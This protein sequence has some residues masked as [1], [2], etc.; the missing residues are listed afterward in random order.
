MEE[1]HALLPDPLDTASTTLTPKG[2]VAVGVNTETEGA[3]NTLPL[4][5]RRTRSSLIPPKQWRKQEGGLTTDTH[6]HRGN[7]E[8]VNTRGPWWVSDTGMARSVWLTLPGLRPI[9]T[10][11]G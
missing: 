3:L 4:H 6:V 1:Q 7:K 10:G 8:C 2:S 11:D 9:V 5:K